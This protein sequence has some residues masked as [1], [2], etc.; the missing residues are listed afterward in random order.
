MFQCLNEG[1]GGIGMGGLR[2]SRNATLRLEWIWGLGWRLGVRMVIVAEL[3]WKLWWSG[4]G[5]F[6]GGWVKLGVGNGAE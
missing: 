3:E 2:W 6:N 5:R 1:C 4:N